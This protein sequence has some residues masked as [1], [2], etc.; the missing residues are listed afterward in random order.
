MRLPRYLLL[1]VPYIPTK[2]KS[3]VER[4]LAKN[5]ALVRHSLFPLQTRCT[6]P[7]ACFARKLTYAGQPKAVASIGLLHFEVLCCLANIM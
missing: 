4:T 5:A 2:T 6:L 1:V 7:T 3:D